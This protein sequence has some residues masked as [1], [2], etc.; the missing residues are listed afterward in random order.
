MSRNPVLPDSAK[1]KLERVKLSAEWKRYEIDLA[2][3]DLR[4]IKTGFCFIVAGQRK[5]VMF[6]LDDVRF[7]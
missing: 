2:G 6:Y 4:R 3:K 1:G 7:E 5:P